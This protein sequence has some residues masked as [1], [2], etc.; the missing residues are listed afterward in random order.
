[1]FLLNLKWFM[2]TLLERGNKMGEYAGLDIK[3]PFC[4]HRIVEYAYNMPWEIKSYG[5][6]EKGII[7]KAMKGI[8]PDAIV[9][10]KKSPYPKTYNPSYTKAVCLKVEEILKNKKSL[11][12]SI[13]DYDNVVNLMEKSDDLNVAPWYGQLMR[14]P[15]LMAYI[16][17]LDC[18]IKKFKIEMDI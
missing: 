4:D 1:M 9:L 10:R 12:S 11:I 8:L 18:W 7:R 2:Q 16:I 14:I 15:Q 13:L 3:T 6:R 17:Q 5:G